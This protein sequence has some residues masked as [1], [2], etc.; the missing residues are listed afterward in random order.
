MK[1]FFVLFGIPIATIDEWMKGADDPERKK[2]ND[3]MM[4]D[5]QKW[6][7]EHESHIL[8]KGLPVGKTKHVTKDGVTDTRNDFVW[9]L[10]M[11]GES[12]DAVAK[13][14]QTNPHLQIPTS[15]A[16]VSDASRAMS[17]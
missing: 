14:I 7:T 16:E 3:Q 12:H 17:E 2:Q 9:Y 15:Y 5:W 10:I 4:Q 6:M 11:E 8:D 1:K 13:M